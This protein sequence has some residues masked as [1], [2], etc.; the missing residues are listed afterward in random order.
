M[1]LHPLDNP[2]FAALQ[3]RHR[4]LALSHGAVVRYPADIA[5]FVAVPAEGCEVDAAL[6]ALV[7]PGE[8]VYLVGPAPRPPAGWQ[9]GG[10]IMLAQMVCD[11]PSAPSDGTPIVSL[12]ASHRADILALAALVYPHYFRARTPELGRYFGVY[13]NGRLAAMIGE[14]MGTPIQREVSAVCTHPDFQGRGYARH[15]LAWLSN[16]LLER[17]ETPFLHVSLENQRAL[18]LYRRNGYRTRVEIAHW[19]L[20]RPG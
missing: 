4:M 8:S 12:D 17:G 20:R 7:A 15:L 6:E 18:G 16:D 14:R 2:I 9:L 19:S 13:R 10:P 11:A 5:P 1:S 3:S